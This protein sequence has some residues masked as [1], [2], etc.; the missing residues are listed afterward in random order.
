[1]SLLTYNPIKTNSKGNTNVFHLKRSNR[2]PVLNIDM[3]K[4]GNDFSEGWKKCKIVKAEYKEEWDSIKLDLKC[5]G[6]LN[7]WP[8]I[9][10]PEWKIAKL[11][12]KAGLNTP[13]TDLLEGK[14]IDVLVYKE[15][16]GY[17]RAFDIVG[18]S[19]YTM[20]MFKKS[21]KGGYIKLH[22][23]SEFAEK[24][25]IIESEDTS[26]NEHTSTEANDDIPF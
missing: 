14:V 17:L 23:E 11:F 13:D 9:F 1:M 3:E 16:S 6:G 4:A 5:E 10:P 20:T 2:M 25:P 15:E 12:K 21:V 18:K 26:S 19:S 22:P 8:M 7:L 24:P